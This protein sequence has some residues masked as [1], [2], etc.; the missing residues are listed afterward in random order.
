MTAE[1]VKLKKITPPIHMNCELVELFLDRLMPDFANRV[2]SKL[3][4]HRLVNE[5]ACE[6]D[7]DRHPEDMYNIEQVME[8]TRQTSLEH[9]N[10]FGKYI[11]SHSGTVSTTQVKLEE[12]VARLTDRLNLQT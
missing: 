11:T 5:K 4:M 6:G 1:V 3:S 9:A 12:A 8:I 2:A 7:Q 10:P